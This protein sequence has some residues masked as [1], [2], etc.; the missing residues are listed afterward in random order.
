MTMMK[1]RGIGGVAVEEKGAAASPP[2]RARVEMYGDEYIIRGY[3]TPER[4][5]EIASIVD[6]RLRELVERH[7]NV[8]FHRLAVLAA[9]HFADAWVRAKEENE[10]LLELIQNS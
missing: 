6:A 8:P 2:T 10:E 3:A 7:H 9:F 4:M 1:Q 5:Q